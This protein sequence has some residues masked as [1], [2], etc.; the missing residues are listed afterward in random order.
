MALDPKIRKFGYKFK[1]TIMVCLNLTLVKIQTNNI[2]CIKSKSP[3][4]RDRETPAGRH[5]IQNPGRL[6]PLPFFLGAAAAPADGGACRRRPGRWWCEGVAAGAFAGERSLPLC[7]FFLPP[8]SSSLKPTSGG[9]PLATGG[10]EAW[11]RRRRSPHRRARP[12]DGECAA[13]ERSSGGALCAQATPA[14]RRGGAS[15]PRCTRARTPASRRRTM[16]QFCYWHGVDDSRRRLCPTEKPGNL[17]G[18]SSVL[19][20]EFLSFISIRDRFLLCFF[21]FFPKTPIYALDRLWYQC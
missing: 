20:L 5:G 11:R 3:L 2:L 19:G 15:N 8:P 4:G 9:R 16:A 17:A 12:P 6:A 21:F 1:I 10:R 7:S 14:S 18:S 13:V